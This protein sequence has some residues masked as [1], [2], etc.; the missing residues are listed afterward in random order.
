MVLAMLLNKKNSIKRSLFIYLSA[1]ILLVVISIGLASFFSTRAEIQKVFDANMIKS[2]KL[3][4]G[5]VK[6]E[7][8]KGKAN[9]KFYID[10][11]Q[12]SE[13]GDFHKYERQ[14]HYQ[15]WNE[16]NLIYNSNEEII[17]AKPENQGFSNVAIDG[18]EWRSY[19]FHQDKISIIVLEE[20]EIRHE[21]IAKILT[22]LL[23]A[24]I[25]AVPP[26]VAI[27][28]LVIEKKLQPIKIISQKI[29]DIS[30]EN[31]SSSTLKIFD[32]IAP[33]NE[34]K[35]FVTSLNS[36]L[37]KL[38]ESMESERRFTDYAAHELR[39][40]IA[41][42]KTQA[43]LLLRNKNQEKTLEYLQDLVA[44]VDRIDHLISQIL[45]LARL[46]PENQNIAKEDVALKDLIE[47]LIGGYKNAAA[48][49]GSKIIFNTTESM[50]P[51]LYSNR[52]YLEIMFGNL[53]DNA[54]KYSD[55]NSVI[56]IS[57]ENEGLQVIFTITNRG[58]ILT[59][60]EQEKIFDKFYRVKG[61]E[62]VGCGLGLAI[63]KKIAEL[64][65]GQIKFTSQAGV[66]KVEVCLN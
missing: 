21:L 4:C 36:L 61:V 6:H 40:P 14:I 41:V 19:A 35:P 9:E 43:Q 17:V 60:T 30:P 52:T 51:M 5:L 7:V 3:L 8:N 29:A 26:I 16:E 39:T 57:L 15:I 12:F 10:L 64:C 53:L 62:A 32:D 54:I 42:I 49:K 28:W 38:S 13:E 50:A 18:E 65:N 20:Y 46:E 58:K 63:A 66:S 47:R 22:Y 24:F 25:F 56:A 48:E 55:A 33:P 1:L 11:E 34:I 2:A 44:G 31:I 37:L 27:I 45:T 59:A 23:F